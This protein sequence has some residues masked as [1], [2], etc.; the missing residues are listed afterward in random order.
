MRAHERSRVLVLLGNIGLEGSSLD[1]PLT[2]AA[3]LDC[4]Q[5]AAAHECVDL[6][7]GDVEHLCHI[8]KGEKA[9]G[10]IVPKCAALRDRCGAACG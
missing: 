6:R 2:T 8:G 10:G 3:H 1:A 7:A 5:L 4:R 9:H